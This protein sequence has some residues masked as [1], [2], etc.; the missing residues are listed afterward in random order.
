MSAASGRRL[1][2]RLCVA[3]VTT[4]VL[5]GLAAPA[6]AAP[7][8]PSFSATVDPFASY[9]GQT[10]CDPGE[11]PGVVAFRSLMAGS[12]TGV[13]G[14]GISRSCESGGRS[15]H[16]EGRA[17]DWML[18]ADVAA[19]AAKAD[20]VLTW[21]LATDEHG[22]EAARARRLGVMYIIWNRQWWS[23]WDPD[24]GWKPYTGTSPHTD[25]IHFSF[26]WDGALK[27]TSWWNAGVPSTGTSPTP[28]PST[29]P[30]PTQ[31]TPTAVKDPFGEL[32]AVT[33]ATTGVRAVGWAIDPDAATFT[34]VRLT[35]D[36]NAV[37]SVVADRSR[38]DVA[39]ENPPYTA[40]HGF[41]TVLPA[42]AGQR[43]VCATAVN[44][45][46]GQDRSL[47][48]LDVEV[49]SG[50]G[51][52]APVTTPPPPS[53]PDTTTPAPVEGP[54]AR[55]TD[56]S[57]PTAKVPSAGFLDTVDSVHRQSID[58]AVWWEVAKGTGAGTFTPDGELSRAQIASF[59]SRTLTAAG[60]ALPDDA[61]DAF[62]DDDG[63]VH[64]PAIDQMAAIGVLQGKGGRTYSP[65]APVTRAQMATYLVRAYEHRTGRTLPLG[66]D[67]FTD[68][69]GS[70]HE[71]SIGKAARAGFTAGSTATTFA[72][73]LATTRGQVAS[74]LSRVLDLLVESGWAPDRV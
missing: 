30:T 44:Q 18:R 31:P 33:A 71:V 64:E 29:E 73:D 21:L 47:G 4:A 48:C 42:P 25:H 57:C 51:T 43:R 66:A 9:E 13:N 65:D 14:G 61:Q 8:T 36:G 20:D 37:G 17:W 45:A 41:D 11:K 49:P 38:P 69:D 27:R 12:Y 7:S 16:K 58:C 6:A 68:D 15:E 40:N 55:R 10:T 72:P 39:A 2:R 23:A 60:V 67:W 59:L 74:F 53:V 22:N 50:T 35:V 19:D 28:P 63:S 34:S 54:K 5:A 52:A 1:L 32:E 24:A 26:S 70:V 46:T 3:G 62:D 56:D